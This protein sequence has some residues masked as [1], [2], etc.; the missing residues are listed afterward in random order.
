MPHSLGPARAEHAE[1]HALRDVPLAKEDESVGSVIARIAASRHACVDVVCV[2][3]ADGAFVGALRLAEL[4]AAERSATVGSLAL[5]AVA[6]LPDD[7]QEHVAGL[8]C[9]H[10]ME[11]VPV[12]DRDGALVGAVPARVLLGVLRSEHVEDLHRLAGIRRESARARQA[13]EDPPARRATHRLPWLLVGLAGCAVAA[14]VVAAFEE[15]L[16]RR[17]AVAF[18][19]PAIV[20]LADAI[21]TQTEAIAVRGIS[22]SRLPL[23][24]LLWGELRTGLVIG[25]TLGLVALAAVA[26]VFQDLPLAAAVGVAIVTAGTVATCV[27]LLLPWA[28]AARGMD[29]AFGSGPLATVIQD[30]LSLVVY[31]ASVRAFLTAAGT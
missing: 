28:L 24:R 4:L 30:V 11:A 29:P 9:D 3:R 20:Y 26:V 12:V 22:L 19:V 5:R 16:R 8:A 2:T 17:L 15:D 6:A 14:A 13:L 27:G 31:F 25:A 7:D 18:F 10:G 23:S 1:A 21:G